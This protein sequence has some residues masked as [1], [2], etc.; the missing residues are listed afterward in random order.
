MSLHGVSDAFLARRAAAGDGAAFAE[1]AERYRRL[2]L[3]V[4]R[5]RPDV[6]E[7][8][9][10]RQEALIGLC[11]ACVKHDP[12]RARFAH[13]A[14]VCVRSARPH[15]RARRASTTSSATPCATATNRSS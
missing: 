11:H 5:D 2:I 3:A 8:E 10:A 13:F 1:L 9:D 14:R 12:A 7:A 6:L 4:T 15:R